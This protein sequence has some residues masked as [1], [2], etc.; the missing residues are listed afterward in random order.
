VRVL[1]LALIAAGFGFAATPA[2]SGSSTPTSHVDPC[3]TQVIVAFST[4]QGSRPSDRF[5]SDL[6][7]ANAV[8]LTFLRT[9]GSGLYLFS[10]AAPDA[11]CGAAL[12]RLAHDARVRSVDSNRRRKIS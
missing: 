10:L 12:E 8:Q 5:V 11:D 1:A 9:I 2:H 3:A 4:D 6:A 7:H